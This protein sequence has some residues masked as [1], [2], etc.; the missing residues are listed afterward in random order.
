MHVAMLAAAPLL[1]DVD[2]LAWLGTTA[3]LVKVVVGF[4]VIIFFHELGH[5]LACRWVDVRVH[6]FA[7]GFGK[8]ICG[9]RRGEGFTFGSRPNYT[10]AELA[11][12]GY[13]ETDYALMALPIG[14]YVKMEDHDIDENT[15]ELVRSSDPRA[16]SNRTVGQRA[17]IL[18]AGVVFNVLLAALLFVIIFLIG[19]NLPAPVVGMVDPTGPSQGK[20]LPG[21]R[22]LSINGEPMR[23][24]FDIRMA[25]ALADGPLAL[26]VERGGAV[27]DEPVVVIPQRDAQSRLSDIGIGATATTRV[28]VDF[29]PL[30]GLESLKAGDLVTHVDGRK[31]ETIFDLLDA[32]RSSGGRVLELTVERP[33]PGGARQTI[34][35]YQRAI[36]ST[37]PA[38]G[39]P[40]GYPP[41]HLLGMVRRPVIGALTPGMPAEKAGFQVNDAIESWEGIPNPTNVEIVN[42]IQKNADRLNRVVVE[43]NGERVELRVRPKRAFKLFGTP[44]DAKV[45]VDFRVT[46]FDDRPKVAQVVPGTPAYDAFGDARG[47]TLLRVDGQPVRTWTEA[48]QALLAAAG[49]TV[50]VEVDH[51]GRTMVVSLSVPSSFVNEARRSSGDTGLP[52]GSYIIAID[53]RDRHRAPDAAGVESD[54]GIWNNPNGIARVLA[55]K[56]GQTVTI[57]YR[58]SFTGPDEIATFTVRPDN[59]DP[60]QLRVRYEFDITAFEPLMSFVSAEGNPLTALW[61]G[62]QEV[63]RLLI[64]VYQSMSQVAQRKVSTDNVQ[65]PIGI[66]AAGMSFAKAGITDLL[67]FLAFLSI[68][69]A[70]LNLLPIPLLDGGHLLFLLIEK[71]KGRPVSFNVRFYTGLAGLALILLIGLFVT[72]QDIGRFF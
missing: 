69:L 6:R 41:L 17:I 33:Q 64:Q 13:G 63:K 72:I 2:I 52:L 39:V 35:C 59:L 49:R 65:G 44:N 25:E 5:Y 28:A 8:R 40:A 58:A 42:A 60:W 48:A 15:G 7:V 11:E 70:V 3:S 66:V 20:L 53:G 26:E 21:D 62:G 12:R 36:L 61:M 22:V 24:F 23:S 34:T 10:H 1:A 16:F 57:T 68:N 50:P 29:P 19:R 27:L 32:F 71:I 14:G 30:P 47:F 31:A 18:S 51:A 4:S 46:A 38:E 37:S 45:G 54:V 67:F 9:F 55:T 43:R 56:I